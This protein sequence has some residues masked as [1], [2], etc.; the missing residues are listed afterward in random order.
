MA[1][2]K[3]ED[4]YMREIELINAEFPTAKFSIA[5]DY[6]KLDEVISLE[7]TIYILNKPTC[8]CYE[9]RDKPKK[10]VYKII[11]NIPITYRILFKKL[12]SQNY[13]LKC[14]HSFVENIF[15]LE[16]QTNVYDFML[17]S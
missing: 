6:D 8:Y 16:G 3:T 4:D 9:G 17:G 5:I 12:I 11:S 7:R 14:N 1:T 15:L 2:I 10:E 13:S